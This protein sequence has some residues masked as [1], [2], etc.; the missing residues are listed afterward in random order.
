MTCYCWK[1][2][3]FKLLRVLPRNLPHYKNLDILG[4]YATLENIK[5]NGFCETPAR[6]EDKVRDV[7][8]P[9]HCDK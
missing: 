7:V 6:L 1:G 4:P 5:E 3:G 2:G 8:A 9:V